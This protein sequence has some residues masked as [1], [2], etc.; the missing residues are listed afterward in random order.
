VPRGVE[1]RI[2]W[3]GQFGGFGNRGFVIERS[4]ERLFRDWEGREGQDVVLG[5][6]FGMVL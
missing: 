3:T 4:G 2:G 5:D 1:Q 6:H